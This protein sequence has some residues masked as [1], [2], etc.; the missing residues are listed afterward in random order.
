M[1]GWVLGFRVLGFIL[2]LRV[3]VCRKKMGDSLILGIMGLGFSLCLRVN[4]CRK[5]MG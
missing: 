2:C 5:M 1:I 4:V 3:N